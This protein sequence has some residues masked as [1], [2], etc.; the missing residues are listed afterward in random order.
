MSLSLPWR[1]AG[2]RPLR[3]VAAPLAEVRFG[4]E[5]DEPAPWVVVYVAATPEEAAIV[6]GA[7]TAEDIPTALR[8]DSLGRLTGVLTLGGVEVLVPR[9][10]EDRAREIIG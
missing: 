5:D 10:L 1:L 3:R 2:W 8:Y 6:R 9:A 4:P 7:L